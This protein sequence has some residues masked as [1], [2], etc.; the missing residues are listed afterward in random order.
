VSLEFE[1]VITGAQCA[2]LYRSLFFCE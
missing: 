1:E 2:E